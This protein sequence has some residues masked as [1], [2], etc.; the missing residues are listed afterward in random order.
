M[1]A[2]VYNELFLIPCFV[3]LLITLP[4]YSLSRWENPLQ[5]TRYK[6]L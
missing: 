2:E 6:I 5:N 3:D 1:H 4:H